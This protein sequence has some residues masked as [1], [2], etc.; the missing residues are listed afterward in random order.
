MTDDHLIVSAPSLTMKMILTDIYF[1]KNI[2]FKE[3]YTQNGRLPKVKMQICVNN[4][5]S[6]HL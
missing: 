5:T 2:H 3:K 4:Q 6:N 1:L